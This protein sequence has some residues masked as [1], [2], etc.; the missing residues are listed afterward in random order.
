MKDIEIG[1]AVITAVVMVAARIQHS[2]DDRRRRAGQNQ[3]ES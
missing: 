3:G 1:M 2:Y